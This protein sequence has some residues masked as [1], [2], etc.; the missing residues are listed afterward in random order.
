[1]VMRT[2]VRW[3]LIVGAII[4]SV[5]AGVL[6]MP[7]LAAQ[8]PVSAEGSWTGHISLPPGPLEFTIVLTQDASTR[9]WSG[10]IDIPMQGAKGVPLA[11]TTVNGRSVSFAIAGIPGNP[12]FVGAIE[13]DGN[14]LTGTFSQGG[15]NFPFELHRGEPPA[16]V[17]PQEP[18]PPF[19][20]R[21]EQVTYRNEK[22]NIGLA[23]TLT[24]PQGSGRFPAVLLISGSGP[25]D[26]DS[27]LFGHKPF[28]LLADTLTRRGIAVLRVDDR[29]VGGSERGAME[30]TT[31]DLADDVRAGL[32]YLESRSDIDPERIG[33]IGHSEGGVIAPMVAVDTPRISFIVM[34]AGSGVRGDELM[35]AQVRA[36]ASIEGMPQE[37]VDWDLAMRRGVYD[38][39][40]AEKDGKPDT[41]ARE[42]M[43]A[44]VPPIPVPDAPADAAPR[45]ARLLLQATSSPWWRHFLSY[46]PAP[47]LQRVRCPVLALIGGNDRQV[48]AAENLPAIRTVLQAGGNMD[49]T[50]RELPGLN[51]LFQTSDTG[52]PA[53]YAS[54]EETMAPSALSLIADWVI[55]R[56]Y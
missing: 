43:I 52:A 2:V 42:A 41:A 21:E 4:G 27:T 49:A 51:H 34:L 13:A 36:I 33:L 1:M 11:A 54:I 12:A 35:M 40:I 39:V 44:R 7:T 20:Y 37:V 3:C 29:G 17:R 28:L 9:T 10:T 18:K 8:A 26:R 22:A 48:P 14:S 31:A 30:P 15:A 6:Q 46:D 32:S 5:T 47:T 38:V 25:Q 19:P 45:T 24:L 50:V 23:G 53:D 16:P 56:A 55:E